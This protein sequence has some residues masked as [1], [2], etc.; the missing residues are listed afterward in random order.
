MIIHKD[1]PHI[2]AYDHYQFITYRLADSLPKNIIENMLSELKD[3]SED[4]RKKE[5]EIK[6]NNYLDN[7]YGS[8]ILVHPLITNMILENWHH[9]S[10]KLYDLI[11]WVIMPNHV[12][13][14]IKEYINCNIDDIL[15]K[16]KSFSSKQ[17]INLSK[18]IE[19]DI[20]F[21]KYNKE[22]LDGLIKSKIIWQRSYWDHYIRNDEEFLNKIDY[23]HQN[24]VKA[25][26]VSKAEDWQYSSFGAR[27]AR[28]RNMER[29]RLG[30]DKRY[31]SKASRLRS[32]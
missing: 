25:G 21:Y 19:N 22:A 8:S 27:A 3:H 28:P 9:F 6:I 5:L 15:N 1:L 12:H 23:I 20:D 4:D 13:L 18:F 26:L 24:P 2:N 30:L 7:G 32:M 16:W 11:E 29:A 10:G 17:I 14:I 31:M